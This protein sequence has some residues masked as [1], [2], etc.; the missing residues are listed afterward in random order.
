MAS[1]KTKVA[2]DHKYYVAMAGEFYVL[3]QLFARGFM[4]SLTYGNAKSVDIMVSTKSGKMFKLEVKT[5]GTDKTYGSDRSQFGENYEWQMSKKHESKTDE[6]LYYCFVMLRGLKELP[7]FFIVRSETVARYVR[8]E[9][10]YWHSIERN[11]EV[12]ET[13]RRTFRIGTQPNTTAQHSYT[14]RGTQDFN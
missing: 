10:K 6:D 1:Q 4:A 3:A 2:E 14:S 8:W 5:A 9:Y 7:R 11:W 13:P 12:Q